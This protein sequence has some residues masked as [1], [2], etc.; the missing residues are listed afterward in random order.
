VT[1]ATID[2]EKRNE[3]LRDSQKM[4]AVLTNEDEDEDD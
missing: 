3:N 4:S 1:V 2:G